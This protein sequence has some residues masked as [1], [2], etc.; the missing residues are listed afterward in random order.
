MTAQGRFLKIQPVSEL[1]EDIA[2]VDGQFFVDAIKFETPGVLKYVLI[3]YS[4]RSCF[5]RFCLP[6]M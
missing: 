1:V 6:I 5:W 4:I 3:S 2:Q